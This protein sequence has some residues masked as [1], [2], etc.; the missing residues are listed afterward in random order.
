MFAPAYMGRK[1]RAKPIQSFYSHSQSIRKIHN[2]ST[3]AGTKV[4]H[5]VEIAADSSSHADL[6]AHLNLAAYGDEK[7]L[8]S[9]QLISMEAPSSPLSSRPKR[10]RISYLAELTMTTDAALRRESRT[11]FINATTLNRKSGGA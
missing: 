9:H 3:Y 11:N 10:T 1:R 8:S 2:R 5:P 7:R 6:E 4:G